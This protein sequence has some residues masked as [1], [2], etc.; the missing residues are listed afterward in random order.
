MSDVI[1]TVEAVARSGKAIMVAG[2]WYSAYNKNQI[3]PARKGDAVAFDFTVKGDFK[4]ISGNVT[5]TSASGEDANTPAE[6]PSA[7][8]K[9]TYMP[10]GRFPID[11]LDGQRSIIRQNALSHATKLVSVLLEIGELESEP[12]MDDDTIASKVI[13]IARKLEKYTAGDLDREAVEKK[14]KDMLDEL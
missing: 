12:M 7:S 11:P 5:I 8:G 3:G 2:D 14:A 9:S 1:G 10:R 13:S 6:Q 4:N